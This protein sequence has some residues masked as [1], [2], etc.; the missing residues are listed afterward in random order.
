[1]KKIHKIL[2]I[3]IITLFITPQITFASWWNPISWFDS[4]SFLTKKGVETEVLE[5]KTKELKSEINDISTTTIASSTPK[6]ITATTTTTTKNP[7]IKKETEET[8]PTKKVDNSALIKEQLRIQVENALKAKAGQDA[9]IAK[10]KADEQARIDLIKDEEE[11]Q[12]KIQA[13]NIRIINIQ[14]D[15]ETRARA[16]AENAQYCNGKAYSKCPVGQNFSCSNNGGTCLLPPTTI[17]QPP[18][19]ILPIQ[20]DTVN[21]LPILPTPEQQKQA[22]QKEYDSE[23]SS[24]TARALQIK[25]SLDNQMAIALQKR[26]SLAERGLTFSG[27]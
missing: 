24:L 9:L 10:Q 25:N 6:V 5:N 2:V 7:V 15:A 23:E 11:K 1:M 17:N 16:E 13:E 20:P 12:A 21:V 22:C 3:V 27:Q 14:R 26:N 19:I 18:T 8:T 4:W